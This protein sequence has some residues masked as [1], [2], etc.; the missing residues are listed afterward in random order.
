MSFSSFSSLNQD[1]IFQI[2]SCLS[3]I[4]TGIDSE[5]GTRVDQLERKCKEL[6]LNLAE[7][8]EQNSKKF[9]AHKAQLDSISD[10]LSQLKET[11]EDFF[12][13][14]SKELLDQEQVLTNLLQQSSIDK[15]DSDLKFQKIFDDRLN[16]LKSDLSRESQARSDSIK[17]VKSFLEEK[18]NKIEEMMTSEKIEIE[19]TS[20]ELSEKIN[21]NIQKTQEALE[22][23]RKAREETEEAMLFMLQDLIAKIKSEIEQER[24]ERESSEETLLGLLEETC[25]KLNSLTNI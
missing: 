24:N 1:R 12:D 10:S 11:R 17:S 16:S 25:T 21:E 8:E 4:Q 22:V 20:E 23:E 14:K 6:E 5:R 13:S 3:T 2:S 19:K 15:R 18:I 7:F 9:T